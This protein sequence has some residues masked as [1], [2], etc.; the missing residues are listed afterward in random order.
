MIETIEEFLRCE[1]SE[2]PADYHRITM[3]EMKQEVWE[4]IIQNYPEHHDWIADNQHL[5]INIMWALAKSEDWHVRERIARR[6]DAPREIL[7]ILSEDEV[8]YVSSHVGWNIGCPSDILEKLSVSK[9]PRVREGVAKNRN[10]PL[11]ILERLARDKGKY[12]REH[13]K[14]SL[15]VIRRR[16]RP[17]RPEFWDLVHSFKYTEDKD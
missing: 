6:Y 17:I 13:A 10:A 4:E 9:S 2:L 8:A 12:V 16:G 1:A 15:D 7:E 3:D 14:Q 11:D 5:P